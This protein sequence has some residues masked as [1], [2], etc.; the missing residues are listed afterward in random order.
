M[1]NDVPAD[2]HT[3]AIY[4]IS[5]EDCRTYGGNLSRD[6]NG[7]SVCFI[8]AGEQSLWRCGDDFVA[9]L[10]QEN[11]D[12][13]I[14]WQSAERF[15]TV[16]STQQADGIRHAGEHSTLIERGD[17]AELLQIDGSRLACRRVER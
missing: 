14:L 8:G 2:F 4:G 17:S 16:E 10:K 12:R 13:L 7:L 6:G 9:L 11:S 15:G 1:N 3:G 5:D